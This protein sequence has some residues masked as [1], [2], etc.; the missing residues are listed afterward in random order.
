MIVICDCIGSVMISV[1]GRV[2]TKTIKLVLA[3]SLLSTQY[4]RNKNKDWFTWSQNIVSE[5]SDLSNL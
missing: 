2:K 4:I 3:A 1:I 5:W